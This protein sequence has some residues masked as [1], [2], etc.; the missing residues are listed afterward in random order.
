MKHPL[1]LIAAGAVFLGLSLPVQGQGVPTID[2]TSI[3]KLMDQLTE[4]KLQLREQITQNLKLDDQTAKLLQQ[5]VLLKDQIDALREGL[6]LADL[7]VDPGTFLQDI[8]PGFSDL[9]GS[10]QAARTGDWGSVLASGD[11][12]RGGG[13]TVS[14]HVDA[15]FEA[16][17][18]TRA[19]VDEL[20]GSTDTGAARIGQSANVSAFMSVAA[21]SSA[22]A[23][24]ES[25]IR[26]DGFVQQIP[27]TAG[28]KEAID[29]N[30]RVTA[31]LGIALA[32]V[33]S[34]TA[35]QTVSLGEMGVMDAATAADEEKY[36][37]MKL[38]EE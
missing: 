36:L 20:T 17:G 19:R 3:A 10:L 13:R 37:R 24:T 4:A 33:W 9:T 25:L 2:V 28:L 34:M 8:L 7:G 11:A 18:I 32:N 14:G 38:P 21:E 23:A 30:T 31:E 26:I 15:A 5:I 1:K 29:L 16:A 27:E 6:T 22:E 35:V 12:F